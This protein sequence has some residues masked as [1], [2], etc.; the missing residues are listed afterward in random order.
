MG[1]TCGSLFSGYGGADLGLTR[2]GFE[3]LW[4]CEIDGFCVRVLRA[5]YPG[6]PVHRDVREFP[7]A[8]VRVPDA[9]WLSPPCQD[10]SPAG[11]RNGLDGEKSRLFYD[12]AKVVRDLADRGTQ[13]AIMEQVPD[14]LYSNSGRDMASVLWAFLHAGAH[15]VAWRV[16]DSQWFGVPQRRRR[17]FLVADFRGERAGRVLFDEGHG[18]DTAEVHRKA[19][20]HAAAGF[21]G[22]PEGGM[23]L[24]E[25]YGRSGR[26]KGPASVCQPVMRSWGGG[27]VNRPFVVDRD[28]RIR[29]VT[30]VEALRLQGM[31]DD[32]CV[33]NDGERPISVSA[34]LRMAGNA[35]TSTVA[36]WIGRRIASAISE[37]GEDNDR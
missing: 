33:V 36:E 27:G 37:G 5:R 15:S 3:H 18:A 23:R 26:V 2:A 22:C 35:V 20:R 30:H 19:R 29:R 31:P 6:V 8:D 24:Y 12:A 4:L 11:Q 16:L 9:V 14:L 17:V 34:V 1:L 21:H 7:S 25:W 13:F 32:W 28:G 10:L